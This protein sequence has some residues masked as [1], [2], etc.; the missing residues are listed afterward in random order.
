MKRYDLMQQVNVRGTFATTQA[1]IPHLLKASNPHILALSPPLDMSPMWFGRHL[2]YTM[3]KYG[4]SQCVLGFA[5]EFKEQGIAVN[6]LW[7]RTTIATAAIQNLLG[8]D[9][10]TRK[11]RKPEIVADA[12]HWIL[13]Q[14]SN[15]CTGNFFIDENVLKRAGKTNLEEYA[16][17]PKAEL[18]I[19]LFIS[20]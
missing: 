20:S 6:A 12:A 4:M 5:E 15:E 8:G 13:T 2:A 11:S 9:E 19:D 7:P 10:M 18:Q 14:K 1:C 16:V 3:S 17:D